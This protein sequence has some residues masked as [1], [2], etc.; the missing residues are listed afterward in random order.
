MQ[1]DIK[2][3]IFFTL[4]KNIQDTYDETANQIFSSIKIKVQGIHIEFLAS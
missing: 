1:K 3:T 4:T 2:G